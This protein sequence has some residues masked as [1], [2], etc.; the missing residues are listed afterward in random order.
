MNASL[1]RRDFWL[2]RFYRGQA[3]ALTGNQVEALG[4]FEICLERL[5]ESTALF[6]DDVPTFQYHAELY[7]WLG[8]TK[9]A[10]GSLNG[11]R[12]DLERYL[13]LRVDSDDSPITRDARQRLAELPA[14][15]QTA[16]A[17]ETARRGPVLSYAGSSK[18]RF[19]NT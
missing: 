13:A 2:T 11:A 18:A 14:K 19:T 1:Q 5:G 8:R 15:V 4:E 3:Y 17:S 6:L 10:M 9:Q 16:A 12:Q 7:Y